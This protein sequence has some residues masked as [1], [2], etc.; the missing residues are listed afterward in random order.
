[1]GKID[2]LASKSE[3]MID[4]RK[5]SRNA[6]S[7]PITDQLLHDWYIQYLSRMSFC[8]QAAK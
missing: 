6:H 3:I 4:G 7:K 8:G 1:M 2:L 5:V